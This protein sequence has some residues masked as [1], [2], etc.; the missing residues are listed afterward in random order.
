MRARLAVLPAI[1]AAAAALPG[2]ASAG[3]TPSVGVGSCVIDASNGSASCV[4]Q[5]DANTNGEFGLIVYDGFGSA[6]LSCGLSGSK[7]L[8]GGNGTRWIP[9]S[10]GY[11]ACQLSLHANGGSAFA[12]VN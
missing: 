11:D 8:S 12:Y 10:H 2:T 6:S 4:V 7:S 1:L 5:L 9:F 3:V